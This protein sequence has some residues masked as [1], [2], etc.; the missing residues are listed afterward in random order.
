MPNR[1]ELGAIS[2]LLTDLS[3]VADVNVAPS[4]VE[5]V[6]LEFL[7]LSNSIGRLD[8]TLAD[9]LGLLGAISM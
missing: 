2:L 6:V 3:V 4:S 7:L 9:A 8:N 1:R 5:A